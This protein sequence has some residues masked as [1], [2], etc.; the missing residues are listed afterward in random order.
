MKREFMKAA[1]LRICEVAPIVPTRS[2]CKKSEEITLQKREKA[3][4][5]HKKGMRKDQTWQSERTF[6]D[7]RRTESASSTTSFSG[8]AGTYEISFRILGTT[9]STSFDRCRTRAH[10]VFDTFP[11]KLEGVLSVSDTA[12]IAPKEDSPRQCVVVFLCK[13]YSVY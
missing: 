6:T 3:Q 12:I 7:S 11:F 9:V 10:R 8:L 2:K 5:S 13:A 1:Y 4:A